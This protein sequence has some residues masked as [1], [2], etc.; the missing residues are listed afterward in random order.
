[1]NKILIVFGLLLISIACSKKEN[2][3][4]VVR[5]DKKLAE[6]IAKYQNQLQS[7]EYGW[8]GYL[9]PGGGG[10]YTFKFKFDDKNRVM[11][12]ADMKE[13]YSKQ[14]KESSYRLKAT[15]VVSLYFDSYTYLSEL[16]DPDPA[17]SGGETGY[18]LRSDF[19]FSILSASADT[20][21]LKG[22]LNESELLLVR[23]T[24]EQG[25][26]YISNVYDQGEEIAKINLFENYYKTI[27]LDGKNYNITLNTD[28]HTVS[29]YWD[30]NGF[31][32]FSTEYASTDNGFIL[33]EPFAYAEGKLLHEFTDFSVDVT[34]E[35]ASTSIAGTAT[36]IQAA[37]APLIV[38]AG[39]PRRM[40]TEPY[41]YST[42]KGFAIYGTQDAL[43]LQSIPNYTG[44]KY[45]ARYY[46]DADVTF[47]Y[48]SN[49]A[50]FGPAHLTQ[51][52]DTNGIMRFTPMYSNQGS[53]PSQN[54][55]IKISQFRSLW[56]DANGYYVFQT[57]KNK[58]DLVSTV[59]P[60]VWI[61]FN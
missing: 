7:A 11:T 40:Y 2:F 37:D 28:Q 54:V 34:K 29:F 10:G 13:G 25:D 47:M 16:A 15:Q 38:D 19:E 24:A 42:L 51:I 59:D 50:P 49:S 6:E 57:G 52:D 20:M 58:Y 1:M 18:G 5:P 4:D 22:N 27:E 26:Q 43:G 31:K 8:I 32:Q 23:A 45:I 48:F 56:G 55:S 46:L 61:R 44:M 60:G 39:A 14:A 12:Y 30:E 33:R 3:D 53:S 21:H 17:K 41:E 36:L 9:Y 35:E